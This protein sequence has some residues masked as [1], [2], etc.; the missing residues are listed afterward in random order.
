[1]PR[2]KLRYLE[3]LIREYLH[4]CTEVLFVEQFNYKGAIDRITELSSGG[5]ITFCIVQITGRLSASNLLQFQASAKGNVRIFMRNVDD[6]RCAPATLSILTRR[7][8]LRPTP[9]RR[10]W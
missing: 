2:D 4:L 7:H 5:V 6:V 3:L 10:P 9:S 1:M 8:S